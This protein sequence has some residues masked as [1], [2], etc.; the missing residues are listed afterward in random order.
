MSFTRIDLGANV[1][2][3]MAALLNQRLA[4]ALDLAGQCKQ[5]HWNVKGQQFIALHQLFDQIFTNVTAHVDE[6]AERITALGGTAR[7]TART[8]V[9]ASTL[10]AYDEDITSGEAHLTALGAALAQVGKSVRTNIDEADKAGD[11]DTADLFTGISRAIDKDLW[12][13]DAHLDKG[14]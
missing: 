13:I 2:K 5:A 7:G 11:K 12:F 1:R 9:K 4:D 6:I 10:P 14:K 3:N 8:V